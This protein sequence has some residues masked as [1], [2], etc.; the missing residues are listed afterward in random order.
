MGDALGV[1]N[2]ASLQGTNNAIDSAIILADSLIE[3]FA[4]MKKQT[5]HRIERKA[6]L[7]KL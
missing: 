6:K 1:V 2:M 7:S 3:E 5:F 4:V